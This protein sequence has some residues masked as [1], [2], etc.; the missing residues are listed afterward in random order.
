MEIQAAG[1]RRILVITYLQKKYSNYIIKPYLKWYLSKPRDFN[2]DNIYLKIYP[3]VFHPGYF[4]STLFFSNFLKTLALANKSV[5]EVGAGSGLLSFIAAKSGAN[6]VALELNETAIKGLREN[7]GRNNVNLKTFIVVHSDLFD[8]VSPQTFDFI[9]INPPY[10]FSEANDASL[11]AWNCG[12]NGE[13][14]NK[15][16]SQLKNFSGNKTSIYISLAENCDLERIGRIALNSGFELECVVEKKIKWEKN[17]I[18]KV[19]Y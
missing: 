18:F 12:S 13:Y 5:C 2:Y 11:I 15:L 16:F 4:F 8:S 6:V 7:A 9:F 17:F 1:N 14:F 10:F 3:T 19:K